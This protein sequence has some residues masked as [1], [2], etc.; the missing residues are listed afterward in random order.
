MIISANELTR[1]KEATVIKT[2]EQRQQEKAL[3]D[4]QKQAAMAKSRARKAKM[5][6]MDQTR[7][8][9]VKPEEW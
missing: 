9:K 2:K 4:E 1:I 5:V 8:N 7:A 3:H 6:E